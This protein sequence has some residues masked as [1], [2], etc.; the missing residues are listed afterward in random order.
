MPSNAI[1][2]YLQQYI[3]MKI[4]RKCTM[5]H[6]L[7]CLQ[8][9]WHLTHSHNARS[10]L[11]NEDRC[12]KTLHS[13]VVTHQNSFNPSPDNPAFENNNT[14]PAVLLFN[15]KKASSM[16]LADISY[17]F[18]KTLTSVCMSTVMLIS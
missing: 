16:K 18:K 9:Y 5:V 12:R 6:V 14:R 17:M 8:S 11:R 13:N 10:E 2:C 15:R 4:Y 1:T 3:L 7:H